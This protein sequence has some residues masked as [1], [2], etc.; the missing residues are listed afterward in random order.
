ML[1]KCLSRL[2]NVTH[3]TT[4][5]SSGKQTH[6]WLLLSFFSQLNPNQW[7]S[8]LVLLPL[9]PKVSSENPSFYGFC[10]SIH[11]RSYFFF[12]FHVNFCPFFNWILVIA[13]IDMGVF[14][15]LKVCLVWRNLHR[16]FSIFRSLKQFS[17]LFFFKKI[18]CFEFIPILINK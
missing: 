1:Y 5:F 8:V 10:F 13:K 15:F 14:V 9:P 7:S 17:S 18:F 2:T 4:T 6:L 3:H 11:M 12:S 16:P